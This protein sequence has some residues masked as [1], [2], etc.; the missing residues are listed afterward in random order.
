MRVLLF[1][2]VLGLALAGVPSNTQ[3]DN[4]LQPETV[5]DEHHVNEEH[6]VNDEHHISSTTVMIAQSG[7]SSSYDNSTPVAA[8]C[9]LILAVTYVLL[10]LVMY[11]VQQVRYYKGEM[12][13]DQEPSIMKG[14]ESEAMFIEASLRNAKSALSFTPVVSLLMLFIMFRASTQGIESSD[15]SSY[16][17][18][19]VGMWMVTLGIVIQAV[20]GL[21]IN[22]K[23]ETVANASESAGTILTYVGLVFLLMGMFVVRSKLVPL[24]VAGKCFISLAL[25]QIICMGAQKALQVKE[26][27]FDNEDTPNSQ[28]KQYVEEIQT[29]AGFAPVL[30]IAFFYLHFR[31][32]HIGTLPSSAEIAMVITTVGVYLQAAAVLVNIAHD[33]AGKVMRL[34]SIVLLYGGFV[35]VMLAALE[36]G[37]PAPSIAIEIV[38]I[39]LFILALLKLVIVGCQIMTSSILVDQEADNTSS[40]RFASLTK[41]FQDLM[42]TAGYA[43]I[44]SIMLLYIHFRAT[45]LLHVEPNEFIES[46]GILAEMMYLV[47][48]CILVQMVAQLVELGVGS[49]G[50]SGAV[51]TAAIAG[52]NIGLGGIAIAAVST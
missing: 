37:W 4:P 48:A 21:L 14:E 43:K 22:I 36:A 44:V 47:L 23:S 17:T 18:T 24:S 11:V 50:L 20:D 10:N 15:D 28:M 51:V 34:S 8:K 13:P 25:L 3:Q 46:M 12:Y 31:Y 42:S 49:N 38:L 33:M 35:V 29:A 5:G 39:L 6:H 40:E 1:V 2:L 9:F 19:Q 32:V 27:L 52:V 16:Q 41:V 26:K 30:M 45:F 7:P